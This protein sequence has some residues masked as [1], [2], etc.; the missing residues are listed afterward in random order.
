[1]NKENIELAEEHI[2]LAEELVRTKKK[3]TEIYVKHT[4]QNYDRLHEDMD[5]DRFMSPEDAIEYKL[6][7][8]IVEKFSADIILMGDE[9]DT[10]LCS[11]VAGSMHSERGSSEFRTGRPRPGYGS[12]AAGVR[13]FPSVR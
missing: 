12:D 11:S 1:M 7:D 10:S 3:L 2:N 6:A 8:K 5:R 4:G 9:K 13:A